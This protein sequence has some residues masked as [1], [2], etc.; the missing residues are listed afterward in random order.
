MIRTK[1]DRRITTIMATIPTTTI[2]AAKPTT[3]MAAGISIEI[4]DLMSRD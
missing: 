4:R 2:M 3:T 1:A